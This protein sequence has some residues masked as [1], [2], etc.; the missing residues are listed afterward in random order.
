M[1]EEINNIYPP[2]P[3]ANEIQ[4]QF[5]YILNVNNREMIQNCWQSV[6]LTEMSDFFRK[7]IGEDGYMF[8]HTPEITSIITKMKELSHEIAYSHNA[9]SF[10]WT[11]RQIQ[12]IVL[13]G[14]GEFKK[15]YIKNSYNK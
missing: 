15:K 1:T 9:S 11:L 13:H 2:K 6:L 4:E 3:P 14:E 8:L 7:P 10:A 12:F 5:Y